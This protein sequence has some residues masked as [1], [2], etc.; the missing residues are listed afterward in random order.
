[1]A[2]QYRRTPLRRVANRLMEQLVRRGRGPSYTWLITV[3]G[4]KTG[5]PYTTP[6]NVVDE[7]GQR[8]LVAPYGDVGWVRNIRA[9]GRA[10]LARGARADEVG[11]AEVGPQEAAPIL[12][13]YL[14][15][16][17]VTKPFFD[18]GKDSSLEAFAAEAPRH[19]VFR[20]VPGAG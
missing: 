9:A 10:T 18:A 2:K 19:P 17:P 15:D 14:S 6:V 8:W 5:R 12:R 4:R 11:V 13:R 7:G 1:M 3:P 20:V 16:T